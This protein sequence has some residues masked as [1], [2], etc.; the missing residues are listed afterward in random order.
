MLANFIRNAYLPWCLP[1]DC[2]IQACIRFISCLQVKNYGIYLEFGH[3][4]HVALIPILSAPPPFPSPPTYK[5]LNFLISSGDVQ[6][7]KKIK[8]RLEDILS[9]IQIQTIKLQAQKPLW[10]FVTF[11][12]KFNASDFNTV[13]AKTKWNEVPRQTSRLLE[14]LIKTSGVKKFWWKENENL[15]FREISDSFASDIKVV[16][17]WVK[18]RGTFYSNWVDRQLQ[19]TYM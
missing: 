10:F 18:N 14:S 12:W 7:Y 3:S 4:K 16:I 13:A 5:K 1:N 8:Q 11:F 6:C 15:L 17:N 19:K 9:T 2:L